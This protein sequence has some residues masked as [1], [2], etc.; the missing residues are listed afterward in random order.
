MTTRAPEAAVELTPVDP[1][2]WRGG[3]GNLTRREM[4]QWW[5]TRMWWV[6]LLVWVVVLDGVAVLM[7]L[8]GEGEASAVAEEVVRTFPALAAT[9]IAI[10]VVVTVQ[11]SIIGERDLGTAAWVLSKPVSRVAF[12]LAKLVAHTVGFLVTALAVPTIVFTILAETFLSVS[13]DYA[14]LLAA[15]AIVALQTV[16]Y[17]VLTLTLGTVFAGRGPVAGIGIAVILAGVFFESLVP[18]VVVVMTPWPLDDIAG[19]VAQGAALGVD[20]HVPLVATG[21]ASLLLLVIALWRFQ[22]EEF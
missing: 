17:I 4:S 14:A 12:V 11:G 10:G 1:R 9:T 6:Q 19:N 18:R 21:V 15:I 2:G 7:M 5:R 16:F 8:T 20:W 22:R 13:T 3:I